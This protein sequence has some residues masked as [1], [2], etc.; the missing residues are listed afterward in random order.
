MTGVKHFNIQYYLIIG[1]ISIEPRFA[2]IGDQVTV[3][4]S[5]TVPGAGDRFVSTDANYIVG[6]SDILLNPAVVNGVTMSGGVD[7]SKLTALSIFGNNTFVEGRIILLSYLPEDNNTRLGCANEYLINGASANRDTIRTMTL[8][9]LQASEFFK[10][11]K[12]SI[13]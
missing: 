3:N 6:D 11:E 10:K 7:L 1:T 12:N 4:C 2:C 8:Y 13:L 9:A 5:L